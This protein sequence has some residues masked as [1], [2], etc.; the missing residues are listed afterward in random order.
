M[1]HANKAFSMFSGL[2]T[3]DVVGK[4]VDSVLQ[5]TNGLPQQQRK[6]ATL[7]SSSS[8]PT[9]SSSP[10][11]GSVLGSGKPCQVLLTP[12]SDHQR[13]ISHLLVKVEQAGSPPPG[14]ES[15]G[16]ELVEIVPEDPA[17]SNSA[18]SHDTSR[19]SSRHS[20]HHHH[21]RSLHHG[22]GTVG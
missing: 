9:S 12:I 5:I 8:R 3:G 18:S 4:P 7:S 15:R 2:Q 1:V 19:A 10:F 6:N 11:R 22:Y 14:S 13:W 17:S 21:S 16:F 20:H